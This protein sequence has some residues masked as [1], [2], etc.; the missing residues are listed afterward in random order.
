MARITIEHTPKLEKKIIF[1]NIHTH[2]HTYIYIYIYMTHTHI[3]MTCSAVGSLLK[4]FYSFLKA[5]NAFCSLSKSFP[6]PKQK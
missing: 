1:L 3:Y 4:H 2:T 6:S 5:Q